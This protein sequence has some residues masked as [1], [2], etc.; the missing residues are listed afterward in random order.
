MISIFHTTVS[1][2]FR[3]G[4]YPTIISRFFIQ[5]FFISF[6]VF[7]IY[8]IIWFSVS[9][10]IFVQ[11]FSIFLRRCKFHFYSKHLFLLNNFIFVE[12]TCF[13]S[14][15]FPSNNFSVIEYSIAFQDMEA[16]KSCDRVIHTNN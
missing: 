6:S 13:D 12:K 9:C 4:I 14:F 7:R 2:I 1:L 5:S 8:S 11:Y 3:N 15:G 16:W 10:H